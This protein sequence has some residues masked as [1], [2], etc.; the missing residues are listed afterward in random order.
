MLLPASSPGMALSWTDWAGGWCVSLITIGQRYRI[1][2]HICKTSSSS[3]NEYLE[4]WEKNRNDIS[5]S[6]EWLVLFLANDS[7]YIMTKLV[8]HSV[9]QFQNCVLLHLNRN[10]HPLYNTLK[11]ISTAFISFPSDVNWTALTTYRSTDIS[12]PFQCSHF[13]TLNL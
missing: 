7:S 1:H 12:A 2:Q 11:N 4:L 5:C 9:K 13:D 8:L 6:S 10:V 3:M